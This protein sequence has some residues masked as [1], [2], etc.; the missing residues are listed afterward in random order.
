MARPGYLS[1]REGGRYYL[2]VRLGKTQK[3]LYGRPVLRA[4]LKT[5]DFAEARRRLVDN[6]GWVQEI[7]AAPDLEALG[8]VLSAR[9]QS[10]AKLGAP[11]NE[12]S[13]TE[14]SAFEHQVR[15]YMA[16]ANERGYGFS[17]QFESFATNW[18]DFV[19]QNKATERSL[20]KLDVRRAY[21]EGR[22]DIK[23][24]NEAGWSTLTA[25]PVPGPALAQFGAAPIQQIDPIPLI[26]AIVRDTLAKQ[27]KAL[28]NTLPSNIIIP[29]AGP[30]EPITAPATDGI[31]MSAALKLFLEPPGRK[32]EHTVKG[33]KEASRIVQFAI[34][35]LDNPI[36]D[37]MTP[38]QW[39]RLDE[40]MPDIPNRDNIPK[41]RSRTLH[42]RYQYAEDR[43]WTGLARVTV[44]T[45]KRKYWPGLNKFYDWAKSNGYYSGDR[46]KFICVDPENLAALPRDAFDDHELLALLN[47]PLFTGCLSAH[48]IWKPGNYF[49]QNHLY[50]GY[51]ILILTG[52]RTG[53][54]GQLNCADIKTDGEHYYFD[55]RPFN[56]RD[57]RVALKDLRN[58]K[59]NAAGRVVPIHPL[60][61]ELGLLDRMQEMMDRK[62]TRLFP[63]WEPYHHSDGAIRWSQPMSKSWQYVKRVL[64]LT[65]ADLT[66]YGTRHLMADWLDSGTVA[67]R[68]RDRILGHVSDVRGRY[69][70]KGSL[71]S[72]QSA[73][74]EALEPEVVKK[75]RKLLMKTKDRARN[76][77]LVVLKPWTKPQQ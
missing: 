51:L 75:M 41:D 56:A 70:R 42:Q 64:K 7:I 19:D 30:D 45:I 69:G 29:Q 12:R 23:Q 49:I 5:S 74:I 50:W 65:R 33:R 34:D 71:S 55:L 44:T 11:T 73:A 27:T 35:L 24:A 28:R 16:R 48:R 22:S 14:R 43:G 20:A 40:A 25:A 77:E 13:L 8:Q 18:V 47:L 68:T 46:P 10:Y 31:K 53:E 67:Q 17:R 57:G 52:M 3:A 15:H 38:D 4:N 1:R 54:V 39:K 72:E 61:I 36:L 59:T 60:L 62:E 58:L 6:L 63:E 2:Q 66:L 37:A 21:E 76:G 9:L 26:E 32:R